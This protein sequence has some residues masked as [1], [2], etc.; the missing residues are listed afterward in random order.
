MKRLLPTSLLALVALATPISASSQSLRG[1][2]SINQSNLRLPALTITGITLST[3][4]DGGLV[5]ATT[6]LERLSVEIPTSGNTK[7]VIQT[8]AGTSV[9][10]VT[11]FDPRTYSNLNAGTQ[12]DDQGPA[13]NF[14]YICGAA[15]PGQAPNV[16]GTYTENIGGT[17]YTATTGPG[18]APKNAYGDDAIDAVTF[19]TRDPNPLA[20]QV[21]S[22]G[23]MFARMPY[24][25]SGSFLNGIP[26]TGPL[27]ITPFPS[28][29][30][31]PDCGG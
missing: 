4:D 8:Y 19:G 5:E 26:N 6:G 10:E 20:S 12:V 21:V 13:E 1:I 2:T 24:L 22:T 17:N 14:P 23:T 30:A 9:K 11:L 15:A 29:I 27:Q 3:T 7:T 16:P 25:N 31:Y 18:E 28:G